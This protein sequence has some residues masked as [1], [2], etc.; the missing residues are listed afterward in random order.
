LTEALRAA[1]ASESANTD[2]WPAQ[3]LAQWQANPDDAFKSWLAGQ[4]VVGTRPLREATCDTYEAMFSAW[5]QYLKGRDLELLEA[6]SQDAEMFFSLKELEPVSRRRYLQLLDKVYRHL[7]RAGWEPPNPLLGELKKE[8][9]LEV[10]LPEGLT[11]E[12]QDRLIAF[13]RELPDWKGARDRGMAAL[14]LGAGL[15]SNELVHLPVEDLPQGAGVTWRIRV[16]PQTVHREHETLVLPDGPWR[17]WLREWSAERIRRQIPGEWAC[18][19]SLRGKDFTPS[20]LF[21][22]IAGW[23]DGAGVVAGRQGAGILRNTFAR[24]ALSCGR[25]SAHEVQEFLGHE[26]VRAT[27]RHVSS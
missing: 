26:D 9:V 27:T 6:T 5:L 13:L 19:A 22:R 25:Y 23:F 1:V 15:R 17:T 2:F 14:L 11:T 24:S 8:R 20:G 16:R 18:P 3:S 7:R 21:R 12:A 4:R 10:P